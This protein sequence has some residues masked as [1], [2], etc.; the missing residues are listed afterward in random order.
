M[1][2]LS[3]G[4]FP[5]VL[6]SLKAVVGPHRKHD[7][8]EARLICAANSEREIVMVGTNKV[9]LHRV[10]YYGEEVAYALA[11]K[12]FLTVGYSHAAEAGFDYAVAFREAERYWEAFGKIS[13]G[14]GGARA[15]SLGRFAQMNAGD[16][17][18]VPRPWCFDVYRVRDDHMQDIRHLPLEGVIN[19]TVTHANGDWLRSEEESEGLD[20]GYFREVTLVQGNLSRALAPAALVSRLKARQTTLDI[21]DLKVEVEEAMAR[22]GDVEITPA[23]LLNKCFSDSLQTNFAD[24]LEREC[25][26]ER[27]ERLVV[28]YFEAL[29][30]RV[31]Q[32]S[33]T[34]SYNAREEKCGDIDVL[35]YF[36]IPQAVIAVQAK[37]HGDT[38]ETDAWAV[39]QVVDGAESF[40]R[41]PAN[42]GWIVRKWVISTADSFTADAE[43]LAREKG[44]ALFN[45]TTFVEA[46]IEAIAPTFKEL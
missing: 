6:F 9:W 41:D 42:D 22:A 31:E 19:G 30:A 7:G 33:K 10:S 29:G 40:A 37:K 27:L 18:V 12:G 13:A 43:V 28:H 38:S 4:V 44:V 3:P 35:A 1:S 14:Y 32:P 25:T 16:W 2:G 15:G 34:A 23:T 46:F 17:V 26:P 21:T 8:T 11:A 24:Y 36:D 20:L 39:S 45:R 5:P